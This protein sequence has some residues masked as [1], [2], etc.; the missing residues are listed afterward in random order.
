MTHP[1]FYSGKLVLV[2][3][4]SLYSTRI[5]PFAQYITLSRTHVQI[6]RETNTSAT[7]SRASS[8]RYSDVIRS[9]DLLFLRTALL[10]WAE[11]GH[12]SC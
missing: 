12:R 8:N 3:A 6:A 1:S 2:A 9:Q 4:L 7:T 10:R 11:K 5:P